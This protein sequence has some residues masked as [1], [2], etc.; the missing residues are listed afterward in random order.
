MLN[1]LFHNKVP[2]LLVLF[3]LVLTLIIFDW[4]Y[5]IDKQRFDTEVQ[6]LNEKTANAIQTEVDIMLTL[7]Q[8]L[9][10][11]FVS[12]EHVTEDEYLRFFKQTFPEHHDIIQ[13]NWIPRLNQQ[14][15]DKLKQEYSQQNKQL[16]AL[17]N[18]PTI[19]SS[20]TQEFFYPIL[21]SHAKGSINSLPIGLNLG[22]SPY[23][24]DMLNNIHDSKI[25]SLIQLFDN[26]QSTNS[27]TI[28]VF[29]PVYKI[30]DEKNTLL[31][32][33]SIEFSFPLMLKE[34]LNRF[35]LDQ[36]EQ[37]VYLYTEYQNKLVDVLNSTHPNSQYINS[38]GHFQNQ[39]SSQFYIAKQL[40]KLY[41]E[42]TDYNPAKRITPWLVL[43]IGFLITTFTAIYFYLIDKKQHQE[44]QLQRRILLSEER[45]RELFDNMASGVAVYKA[46]NNG[47]DFVFVD[48]NK[49]AQ[50]VDHINKGDLLGK[51]VTNIFEGV[52]EFGLLDVFRQVYQTGQPMRHPISFY[53]D[54]RVTGWRENFVYK[55]SSGEIVAIYDDLTQAKQ[56]EQAIKM[57]NQQFS[58]VL[59]GIDAAIYVADLDTKEIL[60]INDKAKSF[61]GD[62][63]G[64]KC[65]E[66]LD[67]NQNEECHL[68]VVPNL[69]DEQGKPTGTYT[70]EYYH[71]DKQV[72][73]LC[74]DIAIPW[75]DRPYVRMEIATDISSQKEAEQALKQA[76]RLLE[77]EK[78]R[79][80]QL[81]QNADTANRAKS[82]FLANMSHEIRTP[83]NGI[84]GVCQLLEDSQLDQE[85]KELLA[86]MTL[87]GK[88]LLRIIDDILDYSKI[89]SG[90]VNLEEVSFN[91]STIIN[92]SIQLLK[93]NIASKNIKIE[94][95]NFKQN[96]F[97]NGDETRLS[98]II[99][100][101]LSNAIK[102]TETGKITITTEVIKQDNKE[103][104]FK[105]SISD[106]GIGIAEEQLSHIFGNFT[107]ADVSTT[108]KYGG[109]G[110]GLS[111]CKK[112][113]QL[114]NGDICVQSELGKGSTFNVFFTLKK[115]HSINTIQAITPTDV[116]DY[117]SKHILLV[118]DDRVNQMVATKMLAK[119]GCQITT[120]NNGQEALQKLRENTYDLIFMD[121]QMPVMDG[122]KATQNIRKNGDNTPIIA[123]TANA[124]Q[125]DKDRCFAAGMDDFVPKPVKLTTLQSTL[126]NWLSNKN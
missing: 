79:A 27:E 1:K 86:T 14:Q 6:S 37:E 19:R 97:V 121:M 82:F 83:M 51:K 43:F 33:I 54:Q 42:V 112:L 68:C 87:S 55:L 22:N 61:Y 64:K 50:K 91:L 48:F 31:G 120:A 106:T 38:D 16:F 13:A 15:F 101:L 12:S 18:A 76:N 44:E 60:Y 116:E 88:S 24:I 36:V 110:L 35:F 81:A 34:A 80:S 28:W 96:W 58:S 49:T 52:I 90:K 105:L 126:A 47:E 85:Q 30:I 89:E 102:F 70:W 98:Q 95:L 104:S 40:F 72:W 75:S 103:I 56:A 41:I 8:G 46:V 17:K 69:L 67:K 26:Y 77:Q 73:F 39:P 63:L 122:I 119:L 113:I 94:Y 11:L 5:Q 66:A 78:Q 74:H 99:I 125:Q 111:I 20:P 71:S 23:F 59:E 4:V 10:G 32:F 3:I 7:M 45:F 124:M 62:I 109:S 25:L 29:M 84:L 2:F 65:W 117:S 53:Q 107:Q 108:R 123:M 118:E 114:M 57:A 93:P 115:D 100:N 92:N 9:A 21:Y